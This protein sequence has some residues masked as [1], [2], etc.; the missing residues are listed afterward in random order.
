MLAAAF[1]ACVSNIAETFN[2]GY[3]LSARSLLLV[4]F[5]DMYFL[6]FNKALMLFALLSFL[7]SM[8]FKYI[9]PPELPAIKWFCECTL[10]ISRD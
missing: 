9:F 4:T 7:S 5:R 2:F 8:G 10:E 3:N 1:C 6:F